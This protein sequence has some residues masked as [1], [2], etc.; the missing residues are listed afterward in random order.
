MKENWIRQP[1]RAKV[2]NLKNAAKPYDFKALQSKIKKLKVGQSFLVE[3]ETERKRAL[4]IAKV[5]AL[6][7]TSRP[8]GKGGFRITR[9]IKD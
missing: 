8:N 4:E 9:L 3:G 1:K 6:A 2:V 7:L 5:L